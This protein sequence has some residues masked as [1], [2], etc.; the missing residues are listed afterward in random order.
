[1]SAILEIL[2]DVLTVISTPADSLSVFFTA[3]EDINGA[4]IDFFSIIEGWVAAIAELIPA[5]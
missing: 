5:A 1:M 2:A 3:L 4:F